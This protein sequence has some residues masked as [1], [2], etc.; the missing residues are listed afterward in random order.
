[1]HGER[2]R[3]SRG[4]T[5]IEIVMVL[6]ILS[7]LIAIAGLYYK[8]WMDQY[9]AEAQVKM[10]HADIMQTQLKA[11]QKNRQH[12]V[13]LNGSTYQIVEDTND[14]GGIAPDAPDSVLLSKTLVYP[15]ASPV[16]LIMDMKGIISTSPT[17]TPP[18][19]IQFTTGTVS[20]EY[21]CFLLYTTRISIGKMNG[22][23]CVTK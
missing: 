18:V 22:A 12:F 6:A 9:K 19:S 15:A 1:M 4:F 16:T 2:K 20:P 7:T 13:V 8:R 23:A 10:M 5:L 21:D 3:D 11:M 14:S 17:S